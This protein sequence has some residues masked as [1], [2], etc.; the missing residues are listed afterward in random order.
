MLLSF[1]FDPPPT[2][3][4]DRVIFSQFFRFIEVVST[5]LFIDSL[6]FFLIVDS[7]FADF[8]FLR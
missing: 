7:F 3:F 2:R 1:S 5:G 8:F 6:F 4:F